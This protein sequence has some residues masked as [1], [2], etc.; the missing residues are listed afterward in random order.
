MGGSREVK[1]KDPVVDRLKIRREELGLSQLDLA[2]L[3]DTH[4]SSISEMETGEVSPTLRTLRKVAEILKMEIELK[5]LV[6]VSIGRDIIYLKS[7]EADQLERELLARRWYV[8]PNDLIGGFCVMPVD[9]PP[10]CGCFSIADFAN[11]SSAIH[12]VEL[13]NL[14]V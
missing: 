7:L 12:I 11:E 3:S 2:K 10:S 4:Q 1:V 9:A 14:N 5:E 6:S 8:H 13:H